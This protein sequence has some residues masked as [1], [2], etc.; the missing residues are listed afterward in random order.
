MK[1]MLRRTLGGQRSAPGEEGQSLLETAVAMPFLLGIAFNL[2]NVGY[3]W[4]VVLALSAAPRHA[5]QYAS[6]GGQASATVSA[7]G[8]TAVSNLVYE[9]LTNAIVGA[10]TSNVAVRVCTSAKGVNSTT[11]VALC[12]Q[13]GPAFSFSAAPADP[14]APVYVLDRVDVEYTVTPIIPGAAFNVVLPSNLQFHRQVSM[15][16]LF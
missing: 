9:N 5:V 4:F 16:S 1:N 10:T 11:H 7:P 6:Q 13:F 8:T 12:D 15:R 3:F 14:E 2:I